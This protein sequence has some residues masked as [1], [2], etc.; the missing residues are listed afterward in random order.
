MPMVRMCG[1]YRRLLRTGKPANVVT[2][3]IAREL[4]AFVWAIANH[5]HA[6]NC[7]GPDATAPQ[8]RS[9]T[10]KEPHPTIIVLRTAGRGGRSGQ[11]ST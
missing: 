1:R 8:Q 7:R 9:A 2:V 4:P 6:P 3:A 10:A 11:P 5:S